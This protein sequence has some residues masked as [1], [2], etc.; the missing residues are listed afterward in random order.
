MSATARLLRQGKI[1]ICAASPMLDLAT[2]VEMIPAPDRATAM[3]IINKV[4]E[5]C[6]EQ[7]EAY[8]TLNKSLVRQKLGK[9]PAPPEP[10]D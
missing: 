9:Y 6:A 2:L 1:G 3:L 8:E 4:I 5:Q 10:E 7:V